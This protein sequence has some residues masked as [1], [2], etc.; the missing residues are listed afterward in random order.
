MISPHNRSKSVFCLATALLSLGLVC[1]CK[2]ATADSREELVRSLKGANVDGYH[3][4]TEEGDTQVI[5]SLTNS[6]VRNPIRLD[7]DES[8]QVLRYTSVKDKGTNTTRTYKTEAIRS[9]STLT[10]Q[11]SDI[12]TGEVASRKAFPAAAPHDRTGAGGSS[13][14]FDSLE[15]CIADFN[16]TKKG[17]IQC[18]ANRTCEDQFAALTCC[19]NNGQCFSVHLIIRPTSLRCRLAGV[20]PNLEGLVFTQ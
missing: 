9:G 11:V 10:I 13:P 18:E 6:S 17:A 16:C 3:F 12:A 7:G 14:T 5:N 20:I 1:S 4:A 8:N 2:T 19:L 15:D